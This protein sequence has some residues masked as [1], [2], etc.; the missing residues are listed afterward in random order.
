MSH[1]LYG[2]AHSL[3]PILIQYVEEQ[4]S[5]M[6]KYDPELEIELGNENNEVLLRYSTT[7]DRFPC[8]MLIKNNSCKNYVH[9]KLST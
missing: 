7:P 5:A 8:F 2:F 4:L 1:K 3:N 6:L 9:A